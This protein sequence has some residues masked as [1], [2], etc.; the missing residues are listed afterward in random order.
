ML[1]VKKQEPE[2]LD[3]RGEDCQRRAVL[4]RVRLRQVPAGGAEGIL[5]PA[6][7]VDGAG[8]PDGAGRVLADGE[9]VAQ[10][11]ENRDREGVKKFI[12]RE[13]DF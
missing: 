7:Q 5:L 9:A 12:L 1:Q 6:E 10:E 8:L 13:I 11:G 3:G 4:R 2:S